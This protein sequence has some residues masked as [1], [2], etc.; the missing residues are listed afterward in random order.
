MSREGPE[1][2]KFCSGPIVFASSVRFQSKK[3]ISAYMG[4]YVAI[5]TLYTPRDTRIIVSAFA[6]LSKAFSTDFGSPKFVK[7]VEENIVPLPYFL[8]FLDI[9]SSMDCILYNA[10][11]CRKNNLFLRHLLAGYLFLHVPLVI[12][13]F[14]LP[15]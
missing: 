14:F 4:A 9:L 13:Y 1:Q 12:P 10:L 8:T 15:F 5:L 11:F 7:S 2:K 6:I 3:C